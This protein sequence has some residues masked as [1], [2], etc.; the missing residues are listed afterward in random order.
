MDWPAPPRTLLLGDGPNHAELHH[1]SEHLVRL[2]YQALPLVPEL[3]LAGDGLGLP[4]VVCEL[5]WILDPLLI[6][7]SLVKQPF[8][9]AV[10]WDIVRLCL[11]S[12][13]L[14]MDSHPLQSYLFQVF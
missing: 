9:M 2:L 11:S 4:V 5:G 10:N 13:Q 8:L 3:P 14:Q 1:A 7:L 12:K 6:I